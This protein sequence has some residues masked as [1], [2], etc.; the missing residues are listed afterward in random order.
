MPHISILTATLVATDL[1]RGSI[2]NAYLEARL[3][4]ARPNR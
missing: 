1:V 4:T 2:Q 3:I